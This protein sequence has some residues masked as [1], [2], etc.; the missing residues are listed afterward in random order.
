MAVAAGFDHS[1]GLKDDG[2]VVAWGDNDYGQC[3]VPPPNEGF[4][5]VAGGYAHSAGLKE[6]G[7]V[8][9]W[10]SNDDG[11]C[12]VP[13]PNGGFM[14]LAAGRCHSLGLKKTVLVACEPP[15]DGSLPKTENNIILCV[16]NQAITLPATG[17]PLIIRD[18]TNGCADVSNLFSYSIDTDDPNGCTLEA[19]ET[20]PNDPNNHDLLPDMTWYQVESAPDWNGVAPFVFEVYTL[21]GDGNNSGRVTM[22]D[23]SCVKAALG[24]RGDVRAD[25]NGTRRVTAAD[26]SVVKAYLGN[27]AP[28]KP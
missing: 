20:D 12:D 13:S 1:L 25:L 11:Q 5:A 27:R 18:V 7:S 22:A 2:S 16:F 8:V 28:P 9:V 19:R 26:Y 14:A 24:D 23:Y 4:V 10:G 21:V 15:A 6:D 17:N 3:N